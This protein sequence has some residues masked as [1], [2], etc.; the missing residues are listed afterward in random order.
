M[1]PM[2]RDPGLLEELLFV[3]IVLAVS[4]RQGSHTAETQATQIFASQKSVIWAVI[5]NDLNII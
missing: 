4:P 5:P 3:S 2:H 1:K